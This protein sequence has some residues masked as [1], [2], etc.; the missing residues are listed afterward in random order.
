MG[1]LSTP[2]Y[3]SLQS[4]LIYVFSILL[5]TPG[6]IA[7]YI[8]TLADG[9]TLVAGGNGYGAKCS[10]EI[11]RLGA[12]LSTGNEWNSRIPRS[13]CQIIWRSVSH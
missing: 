5:Q 4:L 9:I 13:D 6:K 2:V 1:V 10:D 12:K 7:P 8:D 11:G 3:P